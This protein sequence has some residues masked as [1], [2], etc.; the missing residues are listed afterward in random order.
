MSDVTSPRGVKQ[1]CAGLCG[2]HNSGWMATYVMPADSSF[3]FCLFH[4][5][6]LSIQ[7]QSIPLHL[8]SHDTP[9]L[10]LLCPLLRSPYTCK[11]L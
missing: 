9:I 8:R 6:T 4:G 1:L 3:F 2:T 5:Y 11:P 10:L 7:N